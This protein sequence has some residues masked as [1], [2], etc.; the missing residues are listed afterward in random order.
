MEGTQRQDRLRMVLMVATLLSTPSATAA[1]SVLPEGSTLGTGSLISVF[2]SLAVVLGLIVLVGWVMKR[3]QRVQR[4]G[5]AMLE[6]V[7]VLPVG[8]KEK[9]LLVRAGDQRLL[10]GI[11]PGQLSNLGTLG[12]GAD[13]G[14]EL[15]DPAASPGTE[16]KFELAEHAA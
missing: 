4:G 11:T 12:P 6:V 15:A 7:D 13:L 1:E 8:P 14:L 9:I 16:L 10:I 3:M 2:F 5:S